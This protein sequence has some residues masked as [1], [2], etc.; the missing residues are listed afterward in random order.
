MYQFIINS[1]T[2]GILWVR[3]FLRIEPRLDRND[4]EYD[5]LFTETDDEKTEGI[6]NPYD[7]EEVSIDLYSLTPKTNSPALTIQIPE[8]KIF[9]F[10]DTET[11]G[12]PQ[13]KSFGKYF[14]PHYINYYDGSRMIE[15]G[16]MICDDVGNI[17]KER[18]F[19]IKPNGFTIKNTK[20]HG[21][22]TEHAIAHGIPIHEALEIFYSDLKMVD[23]IVCHNIDFDIHILLAE[24][25]REYRYETEIIKKIKSIPKKCT[26]EMGKRVFKLKKNPRLVEL[27][28][29]I[30]E[31][32]P[33]QEHR[34]LSD[35]RLCYDC[36]FNIHK[37]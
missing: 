19:L 14:D 34:A 13:Q 28:R 17:I 16:Y 3:S 36:Y 2:R 8:P 27:Y 10:L 32:E 26:M 9:M 5:R 31:N 23:K 12:I 11:T 4:D 22:A 15:L 24:C 7:L 6:E 21:I 1:F 30:F 18:S 29:I 20:I 33:V 35:V 25:Y 37:S